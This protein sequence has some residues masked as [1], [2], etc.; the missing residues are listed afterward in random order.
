MFWKILILVIK[1]VNLI[2]KVINDN[3][4]I[5]VEILNVNN[6]NELIKEENEEIN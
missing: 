2:S 4:K 6:D 5:F 1:W 3:S